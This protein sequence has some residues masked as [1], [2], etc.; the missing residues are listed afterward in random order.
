[1]FSMNNKKELDPLA[2]M[3]E[4]KKDNVSL[5]PLQENV[6]HSSGFLNPSVPMNIFKLYCSV[7]K[8]MNIKLCSSGC[9]GH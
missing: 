3:L 5:L 6:I 7:L 2:V 4:A 9:A 1:M 8:P